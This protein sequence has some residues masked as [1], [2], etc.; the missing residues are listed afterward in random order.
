MQQWF[1]SLISDLPPLYWRFGRETT[2]W[3]GMHPPFSMKKQS[4]GS[5]SHALWTKPPTPT[6]SIRGFLSVQQRHTTSASSA[7]RQ[8]SLFTCSKTTEGPRLVQCEHRSFLQKKKITNA[9]GILV[10]TVPNLC[11]Y[12]VIL[13]VLPQEFCCNISFHNLYQH[14]PGFLEITFL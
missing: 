4:P 12:W 14:H 13:R 11:K 5:K 9:V 1:T 7:D 8:Q 10:R 3:R 2:W 6:F